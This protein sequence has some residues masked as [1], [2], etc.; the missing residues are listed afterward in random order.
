M[1]A[2]PVLIEKLHFTSTSSAIIS[3]LLTGA[4]DCRPENFMVRFVREKGAYG[5][6]AEVERVELLG[7]CTDSVYEKTAFSYARIA[8]AYSNCKPPSADQLLALRETGVRDVGIGFNCLFFLPQMDEPVDPEIATF[9][10]STPTV[11][12]E[13]VCSWLKFLFQQNKRFEALKVSGGFSAQDFEA[14]HLPIQ[15][16][17]GESSSLDNVYILRR[18]VSDIALILLSKMQVR[19]SACCSGCRS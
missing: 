2:N 18:C 5:A 9:F 11:P 19:R 1:L 15:I 14:L 7:V 12:E 3:S 17:L 16:P 8:D 10:R 13:V 6:A 4:G